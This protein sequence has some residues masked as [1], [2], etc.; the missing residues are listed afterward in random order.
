MKIQNIILLL[1]GWLFVLPAT[2][3]QANRGEYFFNAYVDYGKGTSFA[4]SQGQASLELD[5]SKVETG[6]HT[7][8]IR[9]KN[10]EGHWSQTEK[11]VFYKY[12]APAASKILEAEYFIDNYK[13]FGSG[14]KIDLEAGKDDYLI[15]IGDLDQGLHLLYLRTKNNQGVWSQP[16]TSVFY[17]VDQDIAKIVSLSY[18]FKGEDFTSK[19][20]T[21]DDFEPSTEVTFGHN[22]FLANAE[23]LE[24]GKEYLILITAI[25]EKGQ[26]SMISSALFTYKIGTPITVA[27]IE[28]ANLSCFGADDGKVTVIASNGEENDLEYSLDNKEYSSEN[29]FEKLAAGDYTVYIRSK[30]DTGYVVEETFTITS[31]T[32]LSVSFQNVV[33]PGCSAPGSF[34]AVAA[35]GSGSYTY[36]VGNQGNFQNGNTF[37]DLAAGTYRLTVRDTNG[38]EAT[39]EVTLSASGQAPPVP[40][41]TVQNPSGNSSEVTLVSSAASGNQW[42][43]NGT[44]ISGASSRTLKITQSGSYQVR[45]TSGAECSS[46]S[47]AMDIQWV[48]ITI[49]R[50]QTVAVSCSGAEN[51]KATITAKVGQGNLTYSLDGKTFSSSNVFE[52]LAAGSYTAFVRGSQNTGYVVSEKFTIASPTPLKLSLQNVVQPGCP[53]DETGSFRAAASGG[54]GAYTYRIGTQGDFKSATQFDKL[55][56]GIYQVT[57]RDANGCEASAEVTLSVSGQLPPKPTISIEGTDG[58]SVEVSLVSSSASANQWLKDGEAIPGATGQKLE[59]AE[60]GTYQVM[61]TGTGGCVSVSE[62]VTLTSAPETTTLN[63]K[64]YPNPAE[65]E[66]RIGFGRKTYIDRI[67]LYSLDGVKLRE[68][69]EEMVLSDIRIDLTDLSPGSYI[70]QVEGVG[71]FERLKLIKK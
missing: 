51:G 71:L 5:I 24:E 28:T 11:S 53:G 17:V 29:V 44:P 57:V 55:G 7:L 59:I 26:R 18:Q 66:T 12:Y 41:V 67:S 35:G 62:A 32:Q 23:D 69:S 25:N 38:C 40:T 54:T 43:R 56:A 4:L 61:V 34:R 33:Q 45:V 1:I 49:E 8:Y 37:G 22:Q 65:N 31:P 9:V 64:L 60:A 46:V 14:T 68:I 3:Q 42:L 19:T 2:A 63:L 39:A 27:K 48:P 15:D 52:K 50:I 47:K 13:D 58:I 20:Y 16:Q 70:I 6:L 21:F 10:S 30:N 36:R